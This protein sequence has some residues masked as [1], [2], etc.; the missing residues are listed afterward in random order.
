MLTYGTDGEGEGGEGDR[1]ME[2]ETIHEHTYGLMCLRTCVA[3]FTFE[4][5]PAPE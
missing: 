4:P 2:R 3:L 1:E 5:D